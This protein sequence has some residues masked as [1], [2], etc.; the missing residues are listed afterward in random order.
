[1]LHTYFKAYDPTLSKSVS[2]KFLIG[3]VAR[4][5]Y[6]GIKRDEVLILEGEQGIG[7]STALNILA[8]DDYF[9]DSL[10]N[11][12]DKEAAQL[13]QGVW[14]VELGELAALRRSEVEDVKRFIVARSDSFRPPYGRIPVKRPRTMIFAATT[15]AAEHLKDTTGSRRFWP[16][17]LTGKINLPGLVRDRDQLFA[18]A[19]FRL[20]M[21]ERFHLS[22]EEEAAF[23]DV[24]EAAQEVDPWSNRVETWLSGQVGPITMAS[25]FNGALGV[26]FERQDA[27]KARR[28]VAI[29]RKCGW[30]QKKTGGQRLYIRH[31]I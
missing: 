1:M 4:A 13:L 5:Y 22:P 9:L 25:I 17:K 10:P 28:L 31:E 14:L 15:N 21:G 16:I 26:P 6:P 27:G 12:H 20:T 2:G 18:E 3:M 7:K 29:L 11:L 8:G 24:R 23:A 30:R 19:R